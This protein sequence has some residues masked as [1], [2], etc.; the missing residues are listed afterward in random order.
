VSLSELTA[1][2]DRILDHYDKWLEGGPRELAPC[3]DFLE[4]SCFALTIPLAETA[5]ALYVLRDG[6]AEVLAAGSEADHG[7]TV[8]QVNG[9]FEGL[10]RD[11]LRRY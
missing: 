6:I 8:R 5:Y 3:L 7:E 11:L 1:L 10:V 9:F 2:I 4:N